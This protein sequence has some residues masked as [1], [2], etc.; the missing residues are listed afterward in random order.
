MNDSALLTLLAIVVG[1]LLAGTLVAEYLRHAATADRTIRI[2]TNLRARMYAWWIMA[3]IFVVSI[4]LG[5]ITTVVLF[6]LSSFLAFREFITLTPT[7][8]GDHRALFWAFFIIIPIQYWLVGIQWYSVFSIFI[9]VYA[10]L[11]IPARIALAGDAERYL[12]RTAKIQ[13]GLMVCVYFVSH[14]PALLMLQIPG[15]EGRNASLLFF[16]ILAVQLNDVLQ[17]VTGTLF[18][19]KP[20]A[21]T[22][23]PNKTWEGFLGGLVC[24]TLIGGALCWTTPYSFLAAAGMALAIA[25]MGFCGDLT[26]SAV[27]R[28]LGVKDYSA[29]LPGHGGVLD[30]LDSLAFAA[31]LFFH[32]TRYFYT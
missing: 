27:K 8:R 30:R 20:I 23:S 4:L 1:A 9:P 7:R 17:Y 6:G 31:P 13:W 10:F 16:F 12:E 11:L 29:L 32:L 19:R 24:T 15:Y 25:L 22:I 3:G 26:M 2:A 18:G 21:P 28:D 5:G 14:V